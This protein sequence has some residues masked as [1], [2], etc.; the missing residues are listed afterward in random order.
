MQVIEIEKVIALLRERK[1]PKVGEL[2]RI[3]MQ[4]SFDIPENSGKNSQLDMLNVYYPSPLIC[5]YLT[6]VNHYS[7]AIVFHEWL[8]DLETGMPKRCVDILHWTQ[9][10]GIDPDDAII[11]SADW[12]DLS[13][14]FYI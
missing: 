1:V 6:T 9:D 10:M 4:M 12:V 14:I 3:L 8:I 5:R 13:E 7:R 11:E 2:H